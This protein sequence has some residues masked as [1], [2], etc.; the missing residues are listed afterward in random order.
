FIP[1]ISMIVSSEV[2]HYQGISCYI[3]LGKTSRRVLRFLFWCSSS[4]KVI[5]VMVSRPAN[6]SGD[7]C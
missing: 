3:L 2:E 5:W 6:E 1:E 7:Y 4:D